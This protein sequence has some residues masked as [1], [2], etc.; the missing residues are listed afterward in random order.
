MF[1]PGTAA[2]VHMAVLT[3]MLG[4][5][6][7]VSQ[8]GFLE[9]HLVDLGATLTLQSRL[10]QN[11]CVRFSVNCLEGPFKWRG[12]HVPISNDWSITCR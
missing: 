1:L 10:E 5:T 6:A 7:D 3:G 12:P 8:A 9:R 4:K 11:N 2:Y